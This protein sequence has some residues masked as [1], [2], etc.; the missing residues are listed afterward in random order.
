MAGL[1]A[2]NVVDG[3]GKDM[4]TESRNRAVGI[5]FVSWVAL[6]MVSGCTWEVTPSE[7]T[8]APL[9][10][11]IRGGNDAAAAAA[12]DAAS[13]EGNAS[14]DGSAGPPASPDASCDVTPVQPTQPPEEDSGACTIGEVLDGLGP[15]VCGETF[16]SRVF[17]ECNDCGDV[18]CSTSNPEV[19]QCT[20]YG[21]E[22]FCRAQRG[23]ASVPMRCWEQAVQCD[24]GD[25]KGRVYQCSCESQVS[26]PDGCGCHV[27]PE[28]EPFDPELDCES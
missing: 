6:V 4:S 13:H 7:N 25:G 10:T 18:G 27:Q 8:L 22:E 28:G 23:D 14:Y 5:A 20:C 19:Y 11:D 21:K 1:S 16:A 12:P 26:T 2:R 17:G 24:C 15:F 3:E 9:D